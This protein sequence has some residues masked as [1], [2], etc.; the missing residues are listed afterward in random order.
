MEQISD[1]SRKVSPPVVPEKRKLK[2]PKRKAPSALAARCRFHKH[3]MSVTYSCSKISSRI[4]KR[5]H[6]TMHSTDSQAYFDRA[7]SYT[8]KMF[9]KLT[10]G[11]SLIKPFF[12]VTDV[13]NE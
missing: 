13:Q 10:T 3:F 7:V 9:M 8:R 5:L 2:P 1:F 6:G 4:L 11:V 12:I